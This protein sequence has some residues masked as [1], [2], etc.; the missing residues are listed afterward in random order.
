MRP[1]ELH[2][3]LTADLAPLPTSSARSYSAVL[4]AVRQRRI[5]RRT[6]W[7]V[8]IIAVAAS[9]ILAVILAT[10]DSG[11]HRETV[12]P[13][14]SPAAAPSVRSADVDGDGRLDQISISGNRVLVHSSR[15]GQLAVRIPLAGLEFEPTGAA[16]DVNGDGSA[17][18]VLAHRTADGRDDLLVTLAGTQLQY[19]TF[20]GDMPWLLPVESNVAQATGWM[21]VRRASSVSLVTVD[22]TPQTAGDVVGWHVQRETLTLRPGSSRF[23]TSP[24][25]VLPVTTEQGARDYVNRFLGC[26]ASG[27]VRAFVAARPLT[28]PLPG[29]SDV[30]GD[31]RPD[32][33]HLEAGTR[34]GA[35]GLSDPWL[36]LVGSRVGTVRVRVNATGVFLNSSATAADLDGDGRAEIVLPTDGGLE[37]ARLVEGTLAIVTVPDTDRPFMLEDSLIGHTQTEWSCIG[38]NGVIGAAGRVIIATRSPDIVDAG[39]GSG[40]VTTTTYR[41]AG[42]RLEAIAHASLHGSAADA[43]WFPVTYTEGCGVFHDN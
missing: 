10:G 29:S 41:F 42:S 9:V 5:R 33:W 1:D 11:A 25:P 6:G 17:E 38:A 12:R 16:A 35:N 24:G 4:A 43:V 15:F 40:T 23:D 7:G 18:I 34:A 14:T 2:A 26:G 28:I 30:D 22:A 13:A 21:C 27:G 19:V 31:G 37:V 39:T 3:R 20:A 36:V 32:G 8:G